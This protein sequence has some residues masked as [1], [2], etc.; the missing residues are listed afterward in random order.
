MISIIILFI[1]IIFY[2][3]N[4]EY[5]LDLSIICLDNT[6]LYNNLFYYKVAPKCIDKATIINNMCYFPDITTCP[7]NYTL[8]N[9][10]CIGTGIQLCQDGYNL[11]NNKCIKLAGQPMCPDGTIPLGS[12]CNL[13]NG[14]ISN[15]YS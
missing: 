15:L 14:F 10:D 5:F 11:I 12:E 1:L 3:V 13:Y 8:V 2:F 4:T 9:E 6:I 7:I